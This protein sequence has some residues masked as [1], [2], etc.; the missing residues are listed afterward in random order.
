M[1]FY[2]ASLNPKVLVLGLSLLAIL[3][4]SAF[5]RMYLSLSPLL[6]ASLLSSAVCKAF[7]DHHIAFLL[8]FFF[9]MVLF[10]A[11]YTVLETSVH[12]S[13]GTVYWI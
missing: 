12:S 3:W 8:F 2:S 9:G 6:F 10:A 5:S 11:S 13:S 4:N 7:S 1:F